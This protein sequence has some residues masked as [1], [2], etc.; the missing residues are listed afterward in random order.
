M[1]TLYSVWSGE[2]AT[3][4]ALKTFLQVVAPAGMDIVIR[5]IYAGQKRAPSNTADTPI[6]LTVMRQT[7]AGTGGTSATPRELGPQSG[8][9]SNFTA[10]QCPAGTWGAEPTAGDELLH[11]YFPVA[12]GYTWQGF[13][14]VPRNTRLG[15]CL[16]S[17]TDIT[18]LAEAIVEEG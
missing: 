8:R 5:E 4:T 11:R 14:M 16:T 2:K 18:A 12:Q 17:A 6:L 13:I 1:G 3:G 10:Q 9:A 7:T 15:I